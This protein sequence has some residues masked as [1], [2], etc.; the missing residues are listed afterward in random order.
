MARIACCSGAARPRRRTTA[1]TPGT[2]ARARGGPAEGEPGRPVPAAAH[3]ALNGP[4]RVRER[5]LPALVGLDDGVRA[6]DVALRPGLVVDTF[7][8]EGRPEAIPVTRV[9]GLDVLARYLCS[10]HARSS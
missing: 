4:V 6:L 7:V 1:S 8:G 10:T 3:G 2:R 9:E 5:L